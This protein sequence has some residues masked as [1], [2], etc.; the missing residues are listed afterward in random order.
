M[1]ILYS[2]LFGLILGLILG[3]RPFALGELR[4]RWGLLIV[5]GFAIQIVLF[6]DAVAARVGD[7]GPPLYVGSTLMVGVAILRNATIPGIPLILLG[8]I[9]NM[10]A[11]LANGGFMPTAPGAA[12]CPRQERSDHL[13]QQC[14]R[15]QSRPGA[16]DRSLCAAVR[17]AICQRLQH[18]RCPDRA[19]GRRR[20]LD[21]DAPVAAA[22]DAPIRS[23]PTAGRLTGNRHGLR[24][25]LARP[26]NDLPSW[27]N[28]DCRVM[29][30]W[31]VG[32][33]R[34]A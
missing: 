6:T 16:S 8:A 20:G 11:I 33:D 29:S 32:S 19:G 30:E 15:R 4:I 7:L 18:R 9:S 2:L 23:G 12:A 27:A 17:A 13:L 5:V 1:F 22:G 21:H 14:D 24:P 28:R 31:S 10:A 25:G 34:G 3:G 26:G